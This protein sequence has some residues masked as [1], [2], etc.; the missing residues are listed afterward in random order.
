VQ[1]QIQTRVLSR[2]LAGD[3]PIGTPRV[4]RFLHRHPVVQ[5]LPARAIGLGVLPEHVSRP[6]AAGGGR[7]RRSVSNPEESS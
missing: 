3:R 6:A 7:P 2:I 1:R 5:G 4:V